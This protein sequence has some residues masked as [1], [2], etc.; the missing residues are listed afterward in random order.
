MSNVLTISPVTTAVADI[1]TK[2][3]TKGEAT[4]VRFVGESGRIAVAKA[5][6][7]VDVSV[8]A[9]VCSLAWET[10][11]A[12]DA[13]V[14]ADPKARAKVYSKALGEKLAALSEA[15]GCGLSATF[16]QAKQVLAKAM[17]LRG[18]NGFVA[19]QDDD[20]GQPVFFGKSLI[21]AA[22]KAESTKETAADCL[23]RL[24][25]AFQYH[26]GSRIPAGT[27]DLEQVASLMLACVQSLGIESSM[28]L[29]RKH[30]DEGIGSTVETGEGETVRETYMIRVEA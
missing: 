27:G 5:S 29:I 11:T 12:M 18:A 10:F 24:A 22:N 25:K 13:P 17:A 6:A 3:V 26:A 21:E 7:T 4:R 16:S 15:A 2:S 19:D 14:V 20:S 23:T 1:F 28:N 8:Y 9:V 30:E